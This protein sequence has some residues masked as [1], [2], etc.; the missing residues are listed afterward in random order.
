MDKYR[1]DTM[2]AVT[3]AANAKVKA[4]KYNKMTDAT[5]MIRH[6]LFRDLQGRHAVSERFLFAMRLARRSCL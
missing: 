3:W 1:L 2:R 4:M 5:G 6:L